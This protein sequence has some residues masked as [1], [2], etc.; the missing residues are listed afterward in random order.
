MQQKSSPQVL[1]HAGHTLQSCGG[2]QDLGNTTC[3]GR[4]CPT[5]RQQ[6]TTLPITE[7]FPHSFI[8]GAKPGH[9]S[10]PSLERST[11][12]GGRDE[13]ICAWLRPNVPRTHSICGPPKR[14]NYFCSTGGQIPKIPGN[15]CSMGAI[16]DLTGRP[17]GRQS[18][19]LEG[20]P[21]PLVTATHP[22]WL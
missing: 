7:P 2:L 14:L 13:R 3:H 4:L 15:L 9:S 5:L 10:S 6:L 8:L 18:T 11:A 19:G 16:G 12:E 1:L 20:K 22:A 21:K 17:E